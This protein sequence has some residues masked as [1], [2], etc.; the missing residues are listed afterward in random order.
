MLSHKSNSGMSK[1]F[2]PRKQKEKEKDLV[3][4]SLYFKISFINRN[5]YKF[6]IFNRNKDIKCRGK[7]E[8]VNKNNNIIK[9]YYE[10]SFNSTFYI[11]LKE[12]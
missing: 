3:A 6:C 10:K 11:T 5:Q 8:K 9:S 1:L 4:K 2:E 7:D 12:Y